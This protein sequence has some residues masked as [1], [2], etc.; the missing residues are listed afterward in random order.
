MY[1]FSIEVVHVGYVDIGYV[2]RDIH[3]IEDSKGS[4]L[5][6]SETVFIITL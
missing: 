6:I 2:W 4:K 3:D 5:D 1:E